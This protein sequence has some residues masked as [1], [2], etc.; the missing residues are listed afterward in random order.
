MAPRF[1][2]WGRWFENLFAAGFYSWGCFVARHPGK[3]IIASLALTL[4]CAPFISYIRINLD[5]FKLFVPHDAPVKTEY[6]REQA[7]NKIPAGDLTVNMAKNISK[8]S[9]YPMF[10]DIVRYYVVKDNYENLLES[11]TLAMLYNYTQEM[12]NVTLDLNGKTWRLEDFCRK[13]GDDKKCNNNLNVWLKHAD[14]LFRDAEGRNN[15]N[16]QL[17]YP[18]MYLFN[19]PKDIGNVVYGV[20]VTG[21]KHE[22]IGA[23]VLTI[24]WFIYFEKTPESGAAYMFPRRAE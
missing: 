23:R 13:D 21:E 19:R 12:M 7:F 17:S 18:V 24:H 1:S 11:E 3:I 6:L 8:R 14:I 9:A 10:T 16:I 2:E 5:L 15:P 20:N 4:F 22:I